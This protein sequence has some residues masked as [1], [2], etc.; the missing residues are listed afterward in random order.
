MDVVQ[1]G[2]FR[3]SY[4]QWF[5]ERKPLLDAR[6]WKEAF[7]GFPTPDLQPLA[8]TPMAKPL[9]AIKL[10]LFS[11]AGVYVKG[12]HPSFD[13]SNVEGD[14]TFREVPIGSPTASLGIAHE[15]YDHGAAEQDLNSVY[16][17]TRLQEMVAAGQ[18]GSLAEVA[19]TT[20]GYCTRL[21]TIAEET[22]PRVAARML[23]LN[24]DAVLHVPV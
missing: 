22:G 4:T 24:V 14:P 2:R 21:D 19:I 1:I 20:S 7:A 15:H 9:S 3:E 11:T 16:P 5:R 17:V 13:A 8:L 18:L 23:E 12:S 10:A 6:Q